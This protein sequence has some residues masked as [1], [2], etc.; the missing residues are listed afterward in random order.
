MPLLSTVTV[1]PIPSTIH[2]A[3]TEVLV[4]IDEGLNR[5]STANLGGFT[6]SDGQFSGN[7]GGSTYGSSGHI[8]GGADERQWTERAE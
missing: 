7:D 4:G 1:A 8:E 3:P 2:G 5:E 6:Y